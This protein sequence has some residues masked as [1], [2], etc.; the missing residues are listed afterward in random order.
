MKERMQ[1]TKRTYQHLNPTLSML[2]FFGSVSLLF[3]LLLFLTFSTSTNET[4]HCNQ[5]L[6]LAHNILCPLRNVSQNCVVSYS[7]LFL[8]L[9][10]HCHMSGQALEVIWDDEFLLHP[11]CYILSKNS[12]ILSKILAQYFICLSILSLSKIRVYPNILS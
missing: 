7:M 2:L 5:A 10:W 6:P 8:P 3:I 1:Y 9:V 12:L 4:K 11:I